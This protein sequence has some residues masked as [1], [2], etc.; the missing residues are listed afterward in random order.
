MACSLPEDLVSLRVF[1]VLVVLHRIENLIDD[2]RYRAH[3]MRMREME[4]HDGEEY[5]LTMSL[6][7]CLFVAPW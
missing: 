6:N 7:V 1:L 4:M 3:R 5:G 2:V